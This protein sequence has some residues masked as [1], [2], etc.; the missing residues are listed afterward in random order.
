[1]FRTEEGRVSMSSFRRSLRAWVLAFAVASIAALSFAAAASAIEVTKWEAGTCVNIECKDSDV[2]E[3]KANFFYTQAAGHPDFGITDFR[4]K[5]H[6]EGL[7]KAQV[8]DE[9]VKDVRV[10]LPPGLAVNPEATTAKCTEAE[11]NKDEK[12]CPPAS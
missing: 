10:D 5:T 7:L 9:H 2:N 6:E 4:F 8:P 11:L 3:G 1:M 12:L